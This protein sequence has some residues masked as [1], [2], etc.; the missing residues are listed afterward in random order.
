MRMRCALL[1]GWYGIAID[2]AMSQFDNMQGDKLD[3]SSP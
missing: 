1:P 3:G 2:E